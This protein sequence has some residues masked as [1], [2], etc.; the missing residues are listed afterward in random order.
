MEEGGGAGSCTFSSPSAETRER[1]DPTR[2]ARRA[3]LV[4][5][6]DHASQSAAAARVLRTV[7]FPA[8]D[9]HAHILLY[10]PAL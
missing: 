9:T 3:G 10:F 6:A 4:L 2:L 1:E 7:P 8:L 5:P